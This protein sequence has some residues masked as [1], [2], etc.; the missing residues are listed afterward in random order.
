MEIQ[1][2]VI[3][4]YN[5]LIQIPTGDMEVGINLNVSNTNPLNEVGEFETLE[6]VEIAIKGSPV[7]R[8]GHPLPTEPEPDEPQVE[9]EPLTH[10]EKNKFNFICNFN[11]FGSLV[12]KIKKW[13]KTF[14]YP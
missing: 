2:G 13:K 5:N 3:N 8:E 12:Y 4:N 7:E 9:D 10:D 6:T 1:V 14:Y 11:H